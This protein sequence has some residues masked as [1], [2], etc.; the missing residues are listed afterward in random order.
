MYVYIYI[1]TH[2]HMYLSLSL[3]IYIY[4]Y[5]C[6]YIYIY[7]YIYISFFSHEP[8]LAR[9]LKSV[10]QI[11]ILILAHRPMAHYIYTH[12]GL[13]KAG[14]AGSCKVVNR[15]CT[16]PPRPS[17]A[18]YVCIYIYIYIHTCIYINIYIYIER[19]RERDTGL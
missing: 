5:T 10:V 7:I 17:K 16:S 2:V 8:S 15:V 13:W 14:D 12:S 3:Y 19:E 1:Y 6:V 18:H 9:H 11:L 4:V